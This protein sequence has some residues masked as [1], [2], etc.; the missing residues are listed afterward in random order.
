MIFFT[1]ICSN[2]LPKA[3]ALAESVK[4]HCADARFV[5]CL[6]EREVPEVA[7]AFPHFDEI[8]LAKDAGWANF[9]SVMFRHSIVEAST[10]VKPRFALHLLERY[11][12]QRKVVYLD[13][14]V[15]VYSEF[16]ELEAILDTE[17]IALCPHLLRPGNI[18]MEM[19]SLAH[20]SY[21][22]GFFA[23]S[24]SPNADA[25]LN[26]WAERLY[27][28]CYDDKSRGIFTDQKWIDLAPIFFD[29]RVLKH[30]GYDFATWSLLG[31][32]LREVDGRYVVN[33]DPLR[34]IHFSG[35]DSGMIDR[36]M[37]WWMTPDNRGT[38]EML[39]R[40]YLELIQHHG[41]EALGKLPWAYNSYA[42]G[43]PIGKAAR[44][45]YRNRDMWERFPD[46][47]A[48]NDAAIIEAAGPAPVVDSG[49][50][51]SEQQLS[52][53]DRFMRSTRTIGVGPTM[54]K[55]VRKLSGTGPRAS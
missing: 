17:S 3:M 4:A 30:H 47:Y 41:Q 22:L 33:G 29:V 18:D 36:A 50:P 7:K 2:Y 37:G 23:V 53:L 25:F 5:L 32:D 40:Q 14:D 49:A 11:P 26:W 1:S 13:P 45:A 38:F 19:S 52:I 55:A 51:Q 34:F 24:R 28:F 35:L 48:C 12:D 44:L 20:G 27:H 9:D 6:V 39:Y 15:L 54:I 21:N 16:E 42:N 10:A 8:I 46:P 43:A 31:S